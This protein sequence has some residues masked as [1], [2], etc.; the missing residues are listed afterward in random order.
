MNT[1][2]YNSDGVL[3]DN[4]QCMTVHCLPTP[5]ICGSPPPPCEPSCATP[6]MVC[7]TVP[8]RNAIKLRSGENGRW[9]TLRTTSEDDFYAIRHRV[10]LHLVR[11][12]G[13]NCCREFCFGPSGVDKDGRIYYA[14]SDEFLRAP[15]GYYIAEMRV[16]GRTHRRTMLFKPF[17]YVSA[18]RTVG[19]YNDCGDACDD[20]MTVPA[21]QKGCGCNVGVDCGHVPEAI[22]EMF[23]DRADCGVCDDSCK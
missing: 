14:W 20:G 4:G 6:Q 11:A 17:S 7:T 9:F 18:N 3:L 13:D 5:E 15:A 21:L 2:T 23:I 10:S 1:V 8:T 19:T 22:Q 16:E 12:G